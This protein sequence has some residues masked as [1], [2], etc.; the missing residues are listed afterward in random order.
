MKMLPFGAFAFSVKVLHLA[1]LNQETG[2]K[3]VQEY[4]N[5][6]HKCNDNSSI[7]ILT[8][9]GP[10]INSL[11][12]RHVIWHKNCYASFTSKANIERV[13]KLETT[14]SQQSHGTPPPMM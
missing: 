3:R 7:E 12:E 13:Q 9:I 5:I 2:V 6:R 14:Q 8:R 1:Q 4:Y 11:M 10:H